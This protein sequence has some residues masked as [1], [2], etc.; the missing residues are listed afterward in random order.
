MLKKIL[1]ATGAIL[2][3]LNA[4]PAM[5]PD[6]GPKAL[7]AFEQDVMR[8]TAGRAEQLDRVERYANLHR[9]TLGIERVE[10]TDQSVTV[11]F[12]S[13]LTHMFSPDEQ[14]SNTD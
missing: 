12:R 9:M 14:S 8:E 7:I 13:G 6:L 5:R 4:G 11:R 2:M 10:R 3:L 1:I